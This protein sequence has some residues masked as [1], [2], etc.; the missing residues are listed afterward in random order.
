MT[1]LRLVPSE[2]AGGPFSEGTPLPRRLPPGR[3][4]IP[5]NLVLEHQRRRLIMAMAEALAEHGYANVTTTQVSE[6]ASVSTSTFY[7]HFGNLWDCALAAYVM[8]SD[9]L[10]EEIEAACASRD[11]RSAPLTVGIE[12]AL[13][14]FSAQPQLAQLLCA[15]APLEASAIAA[16]RRIL[17]ARLATMLRRGREPDGGGAQPPG[18]DERLIDATFAFVFTRISAGGSTGLAGLAPELTAIL[19]RPRQAA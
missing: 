8:T 13:A 9:R 12:A 7:K 4:G 1:E 2:A 5:A 14:F 11:P 17:I 10:C 19:G 6:R 18:L 3:H 15:Q 16:A